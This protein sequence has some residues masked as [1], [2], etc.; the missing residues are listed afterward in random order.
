MCEQGRGRTMFVAGDD[1]A[2]RSALL[3]DWLEGLAAMPVPPRVLGGTFEDGDYLP[4]ARDRGAASDAV[5]ALERLLAAGES[6]VSL[7]E[8]GLPAAVTNLLGQVL[9]KSKAALE[10]THRML[11]APGETNG[12]MLVPKALRRLCEDGPVVCVIETAD[13]HAGGLWADLVERFAR[14]VAKDV[15]LLLVLSL[16]GPE[17]LGPHTDD[18]PAGMNVARQLTGSDVDVATWQWLA[19]LTEQELERWTGGCAPGVLGSLIEITGGRG[20]Y[21]V[22]LWREWRERGTVEDLTDGRWRFSGGRERLFD[23]VDDVL[24]ERLERLGLDLNTRDRPLRLLACAALEGRR[25][26][27]PAIAAARGW[28]VNET[29]D[30]LDDVL[31]YD[32]D[33]PEGFVVDTGFVTVSDERG[34]RHLASY[35]FA[36]ELDWIT[37]ASPRPQ[38]CRAAPSRAP[39]RSGAGGAV[40][41]RW[42]TGSP[43]PCAACSRSPATARTPRITGGWLTP[44]WTAAF[45]CGAHAASSLT[46]TQSGLPNAVAAHC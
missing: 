10:L 17:R 21:S 33:S 9:S 14:R 23:E 11:A 2:G 35:R 16:D 39:S 25:F 4:W 42:L 43:P 38:R 44:A 46:V 5:A 1:A 22:A 26:T 27:A 29:I 8:L 7:L 37:A 45:C 40:R 31:A 36:R 34:T 24:Y 30:L 15:P 18:E 32:D 6:A 28:D 3:H 41:R 20:G 12:A 13:L 19:P